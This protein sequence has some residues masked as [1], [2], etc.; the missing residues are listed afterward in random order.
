M[1]NYLNF[2]E[3]ICSLLKKRQVMIT[4]TK[5]NRIWRESY[6]LWY[7]KLFG[8]LI[9]VYPFCWLIYFIVTILFWDYFNRILEAIDW[10]IIWMLLLS[11]FALICALFIFLLLYWAININNKRL[12]DIGASW[13]F[14]LPLLIPAIGIIV[15]FLYLFIPWD[16]NKNK[17]WEV[18]K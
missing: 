17:Y 3:I 13:W 2:F 1:N 4:W 11:I 18:E 15:F 16:V 7:L 9:L 14:Q 5:S 10:T 8:F 6:F 12:H